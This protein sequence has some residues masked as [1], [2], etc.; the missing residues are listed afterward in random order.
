MSRPC[1]ARIEADP[2]L[3]ALWRYWDEKRT[4]RVMPRRRDLDP[5]LEIPRLLPHLLLVER[6]EGRFRWRLAGTAVVDAY[7]QELTGRFIDEVIS[8]ARRE[9]ANRHYATVFETARAIFVRNRYTSRNATD[10]VVSRILL[11][12]S[13]EDEDTV[14]LLLQAQTFQLGSAYAARLGTDFTIDVNLDE[15]KFLDE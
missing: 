9:A 14:H 1:P 15:I 2:V 11:P 4:A 13:A 5:P 8:A 10:F 7:G 12:L 6:A 3:S